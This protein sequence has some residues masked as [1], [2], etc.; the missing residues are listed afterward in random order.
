MNQNQL[1]NYLNDSL[2]MNLNLKRDIIPDYFK[3]QLIVD[4]VNSITRDL[5]IEKYLFHATT[6]KNAIK[7]HESGMLIP[8]KMYVADI[9]KEYGGLW[10]NAN[11]ITDGI[12][13]NALMGENIFHLLEVI[14]KL[15]EDE[16]QNREKILDYKRKVHIL[17]QLLDERP[18]IY[19]HDLPDFTFKWDLGSI[20]LV[21]EGSVLICIDPTK[22]KFRKKYFYYSYIVDKDT[23]DNSILFYFDDYT[24]EYIKDYI[25]KTAYYQ[26]YEIVSYEPIDIN[27]IDY[28]LLFNKQDSV[29][30]ISNTG[31]GKYEE[32]KGLKYEANVGN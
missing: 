32:L 7:I 14:E 30:I 12:T 4:K 10:F 3:Q 11:T 29:K 31:N 28:L 27:D 8:K 25:K 23:E 5:N 22:V 18:K 17:S 2:R 20:N 21:D 1:I 13:E 6:M 19:F 15:K 16:E 9:V 24:E 26:T